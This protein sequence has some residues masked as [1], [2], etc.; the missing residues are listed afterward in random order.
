V[1]L[2]TG[3]AAQRAYALPHGW[4]KR[5]Y[6]SS[7]TL[8]P[9]QMDPTTT[10]ALEVWEQDHDI[11]IGTAPDAGIWHS[12]LSEEAHNAR[13]P[14]PYTWVTVTEN[15]KPELLKVHENNRVVITSPT[16]TGIPGRDTA[17][18]EYPI[19]VRFTATT[20]SGTN[21]DGSHYS[22]PGSR[23]STTS[24]AAMPCTGSYARP[25]ATRRASAVS[26][27]RSRLRRRSTT[28]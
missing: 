23:G 25:T 4:L 6:R 1:P 21:P 9:G 3:L 28:S 8:K 13:N 5:D 14:R 15:T 27:C 11:S 22:D 26:S 2:T 10:G 18:G 17:T 12:L 7:P 19:Y 20:M 24:T 16:N